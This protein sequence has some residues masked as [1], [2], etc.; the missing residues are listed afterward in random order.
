MD[1]TKETIIIGSDHA[2]YQLKE[3]VKQLL[4]EMDYP[5]EDVGTYSEE[6]VDYPDFAEKVS[7]KV[8]DTPNTLGIIAC[9][10]GIGISIAANKIKGIRAALVWNE[11]M[12]KLSREHNNSNVLALGGRL[13]NKENV[14]K[15][16]KSWLKAK[17]KGGRH[18]RRV[19]KI[20]QLEEKKY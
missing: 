7:L 12:A 2:G 9:A 19:N 13:F 1:E 3:C 20:A 16:L 18:E 15:I 14:E 8:R 10:T 6:S 11:E 17:F 4:I 5:L